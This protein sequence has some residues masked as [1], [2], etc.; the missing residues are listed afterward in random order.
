MTYY[1]DYL[2]T[3]PNMDTANPLHI[4]LNS[5]PSGFRQHR[6]NFL[7]FSYV[8]EGKGSESVNGSQHLM[9]S[10]IFTFVLPFQTHELFTDPGE[11]LQLYNCMFSMDLL[12]EG[13]GK[14]SLHGLLEEEAYQPYARLEGDDK[15]RMRRLVEDMYREY[16]GNEPW[17]DAI[18]QLRLKEILILF[19]RA[20]RSAS[21]DQSDTIERPGNKRSST[22]CIIR[23][24]HSQYQEELTLSRLSQRFAMS[25]SRISEVIKEATGQTFLHFLHDLRIRHA[26]GLLA[27]T[28]LT[29]SEVALESGYGSYGTFSRVFRAA[30]GMAP[31]EYRR[32]TGKKQC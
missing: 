15:I 12:L 20:R 2:K 24:I 27:S 26:C 17:R 21:A 32:T 28:E 6:H 3:Y 16:N 13:S 23:Y 4:S 19:D 9:E 8:I 18:L 10:G 14:Q 7:E 11:T 31:K 29:V 22:W 5:L 25:A 1:P 30:K